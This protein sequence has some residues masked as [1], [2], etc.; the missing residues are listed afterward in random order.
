MP[1]MAAASGMS[2]DTLAWTS[3][4]YLC[5]DTLREANARLVNAHYQHRHAQLWGLAS[6]VPIAV[7]IDEF[8]KTA[9]RWAVEA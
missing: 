1:G 3:Q 9:T 8:A 7:A 4:W 2:E 6:A 5:Q